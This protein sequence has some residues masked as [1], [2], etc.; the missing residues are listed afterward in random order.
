MTKEDKLEALRYRQT[1]YELA[2]DGKILAGYTR[3]SK[4][5]I[6]NMLRKNGESWA[7]RLNAN[8]MITF[9]KNGREATIGQYNVKFT[10]RTQRDA[11][12]EGELPWFE[13]VI[14]IN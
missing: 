9:N 13:D 7:K 2:V 3:Q 10:G 1:K 4:M 12:I 6:L 8:D 14:P 5:G 11:I